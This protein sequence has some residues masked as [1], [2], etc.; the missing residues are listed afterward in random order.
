MEQFE[1]KVAVVTGAASGIG[2]GM[3]RRFAREKLRV[4]MADIEVPALE[5]ARAE[6]EKTG[7]EVLAVQT[8]VSSADSVHAL[9]ARA[10]EAFGKVHILCNNAG[11]A[12]GGGGFGG[13]WQPNDKDWQWV[14]GVNLMGVVHGLQAFVPRMLEHGEPGHIVNTSSI[15]GVNTGNGSI[16]SV[17]KH[18]VTRLTEGLYVDLRVRK[19]ELGVSLLCPG[20]IATRIVTSGRNRPEHL[21]N[22][23]PGI[24]AD[25]IRE[26]MADAQQRFMSAGMPAD[27]VGDLVFDA[28]RSGRFY[29]FTHPE[30]TKGV[31][32]RMED[33]LND[34]TPRLP[35]ELMGMTRGGSQ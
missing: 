7:A 12:G 14:L 19:S 6:L 23:V 16:Y 11:V 34:R 32:N 28:I 3:A 1:G 10:H 20:L 29:I 25:A 15:L 17:S 26:R 4:V 27:Q 35:R 33:I 9:A 5:E 22:E 2:L 21:R 13:I 30:L 8:D 31:K 18:A 24:S